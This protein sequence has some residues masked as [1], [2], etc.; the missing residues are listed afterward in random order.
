MPKILLID[1]DVLIDFLRG[2]SQAVTY[3]ENLIEESLLISSI[4]VA[5]LYSGVREGKEREVLDTFFLAFEIVPIN[6]EIAIKG[7]LY[8]RDYGKSHGVG[9]ANALIAATAEVKQAHLVTLN[10][11]HFPMLDTVIVPYKKQ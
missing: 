6:E 2:R 11:K 4:T 9:L 5:E 7:G 8:R 10:Q 1:T 3:L